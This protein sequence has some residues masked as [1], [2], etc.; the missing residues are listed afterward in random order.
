MRELR[1]VLQRRDEVGPLVLRL[2]LGL[3]DRGIVGRQRRDLIA[4][5][6]S[7]SATA[8]CR[9]SEQHARQHGGD[10]EPASGR[11]PESRHRFSTIATHEASARCRRSFTASCAR[12]AI[13][14]AC[15][16]ACSR[17]RARGRGPRPCRRPGSAGSPRGAAASRWRRSRRGRRRRNVV[18]KLD[19]RV[20]VVLAEAVPEALELSPERE[21][22]GREH[23]AAILGMV[24]Q[25]RPALGRVAEDGTGRGH[26]APLLVAGEH[27]SI[28]A[29]TPFA[30]S[31]TGDVT[32]PCMSL[33]EWWNR[34]LGDRRET[35]AERETERAQAGR[36]RARARQRVGRRA[37]R[38]TSSPAGISAAST[39]TACSATAARTPRTSRRASSS[40]V[41]AQLAQ[42]GRQRLAAAQHRLE[43][44]AVPLDP[45]ERD[46]HRE[47]ARPDVLGQLLP[48]QRR[49]HGRARL[50]P[51]RVDRRDRLAVPVLAVVDEHAR[52][53]LLQPLGRHLAGMLGLEPRARAARRTRTSRRSVRAGRSAPARGCRRRRS[54]SRTSEVELL[55]RRA[56]EVRDADRR[57]RSRPAPPAGRGR[58]RRSPA[59]RACRRASTS[60][61]VDAVHLHHPEQRL[62]RV[63]EREV[64]EPR[65]PRARQV[66]NCR[67]GIQ[68]GM[69]F[70][71][72]FWKKQPP[73]S[74]SRQR[75][76]VN[77]RS[78]RC[79]TIAGATSS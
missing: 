31:R 61:H 2:A 33:R 44:V 40:A 32:V 20:A 45:L 6:R 17:T 57:A 39:P 72:C 69:P 12:A 74:P 51:H 58:R 76:I 3:R 30:T 35:A 22:P 60:V 41:A 26:Q 59:A 56:D 78:R 23:L 53:L 13:R 21:D 73:G 52:A 8:A 46:R 49:R 27:P 38:P 77:G 34:M 71:A 70:G 15:R 10:E 50:R 4:G 36:R 11:R 43:E 79:G 64:D 62:A 5:A 37:Q 47:V 63:D 48:A 9:E 28:V 24:D 68:S 75:F 29:V 1:V 16:A 14:A 7:A 42:R 55:E 66:R 54:S 18:R 67:V 65:R 25:C 19:E